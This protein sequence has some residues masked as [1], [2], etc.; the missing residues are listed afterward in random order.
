M[1]FSVCAW[2]TDRCLG[3]SRNRPNRSALP[4]TDTE[5]K[6]IA[7]A[8]LYEKLYLRDPANL[9]YVMNHARLLS[10]LGKLKQAE[11]VILP[12]LAQPSRDMLKLAAQVYAAAGQYRTAEKYQLQ[13]LA[14]LRQGR[15]EAWGFLGDIQL[16]R[17]DKQLSR[18]SYHRGLTELLHEIELEKE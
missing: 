14:N 6:L 3:D 4:I 2:A 11:K 13:Y 12:Y 9:R 8:A 5:L 16:S 15:A 17:G 10:G 1:F 7:A 18:R